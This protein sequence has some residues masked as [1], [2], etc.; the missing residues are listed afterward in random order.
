MEEE[1][2]EEIDLILAFERG[3]VCLSLSEEDQTRLPLHPLLVAM[4]LLDEGSPQDSKV[5]ISVDVA[6]IWL[7]GGSFANMH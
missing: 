3:V 2:V 6:L 1:K 5:K 7:Q 4:P